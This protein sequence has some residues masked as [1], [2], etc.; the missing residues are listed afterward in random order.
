MPVAVSWRHQ[1]RL[2]D[3]FGHLGGNLL[4]H[5]RG[6][7]AARID[8]DRGRKIEAGNEIRDRRHVRGHGGTLRAVGR[9]KLDIGSNGPAEVGVSRERHVDVAAQQCRHGFPRAFERNM[10]HHQVERGF[11]R[12]HG[13]MVRAADPGGPVIE[14]D[15]IRSSTRPRRGGGPAIVAPGNAETKDAIMTSPDSP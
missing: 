13:E 7:S 11:Q 15:A 5:L 4:D 6:R 9:E 10:R 8:A 14:L 2:L 1:A 12:L 3:Q